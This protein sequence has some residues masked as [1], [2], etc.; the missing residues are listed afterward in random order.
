M[1]GLYFFS[2]VF[3]HPAL[4]GHHQAPLGFWEPDCVETFSAALGRRLAPNL[5][6]MEA[7]KL[8]VADEQMAQAVAEREQG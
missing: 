2:A 1:H 6:G 3:R 4:R 5:V 7:A 8:L